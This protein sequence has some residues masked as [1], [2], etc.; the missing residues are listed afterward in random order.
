ML[1]ENF[2]MFVMTLQKNYAERSSLCELVLS[3]HLVLGYIVIGMY[4]RYMYLPYNLKTTVHN[5]YRT[6]NTAMT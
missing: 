6:L 5:S 2:I 3:L 1:S 4:S